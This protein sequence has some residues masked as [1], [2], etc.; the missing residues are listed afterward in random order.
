MYPVIE[1]LLQSSRE[2][3]CHFRKFPCL[4]VGRSLVCWPRRAG[5]D[6]L[7]PL[8][9]HRRAGTTVPELGARAACPCHSFP[10]RGGSGGEGVSFSGVQLLIRFFLCG[11][12]F[13]D[14][15]WEVSAQLLATK[16]L[17]P[18]VLEFL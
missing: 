6:V 11:V 5:A 9:W 10:L 15:F 1:P 17:F 13:W 4:L 16:V 2:E 12:F 3:L 18:F 8:C 14:P 7:A